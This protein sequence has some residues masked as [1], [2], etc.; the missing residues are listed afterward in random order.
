ME[1]ERVYKVYMHTAPNNKRYIGITRQSLKARWGNGKGY[2]TNLRFYKAIKKYGWHNF[3]HE[4]IFWNLTETEANMFEIELIKYYKATDIKYGYN[5]KAGGNIGIV[6]TQETKDK[7]RKMNTGKKVREDVKIKISNS[8]KGEKNHFYGKHHTEESKNKIR[9]KNGGRKP[10]ITEAGFIK[11]IESK[12]K[13]VINLDTGDIF[14]A[15]KFAAIKYNASRTGISRVCKGLSKHSGGYKWAFISESGE[16]L[17]P[18]FTPKNNKRIRI[19]DINTDVIYE[20]ISDASR[21]TGVWIKTIREII[22]GEKFGDIAKYKFRKIM[23][24]GDI[25]HV[26]FKERKPHTNSRMVRNIN[27]GAIFKSILDANKF[28]GVKYSH[29]SDACS[30][31]RETCFGF[32]WEYVDN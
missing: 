27:T 32:K 13:K 16:I 21:K 19:I 30:G 26:K 28:F 3:K 31:K 18:K 14:K 12:Y 22:S 11:I 23:D 4:L 15:I 7:L 2:T 8:L 20:S 24:N 5:V 17:Y 9:I 25:V 29:I 10:I 1:N 6:H